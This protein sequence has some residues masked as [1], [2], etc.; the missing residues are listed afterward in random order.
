MTFEQ[1]HDEIKQG[2]NCLQYGSPPIADHAFYRQGENI[3]ATDD[4]FK[5]HWELQKPLSGNSC[6]NHCDYRGVSIFQIKD[7]L[8]R[9][10]IELK[11]SFQFSP[12]PRK[13]AYFVRI[14]NDAGLVWDQQKDNGHCNLFKCDNFSLEYVEFVDVFDMSEPL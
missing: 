5:S 14:K 4:D 1:L 8:D 3:P 13:I 6:K 7:E 10:K 12:I 2:C 11:K 9:K